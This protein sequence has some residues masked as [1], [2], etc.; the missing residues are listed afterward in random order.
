MNPEIKQLRDKLKGL[1]LDGMIVYN[2]ANVRYLT[3]FRFRRLFNNNTK[4]KCF[5]YRWKVY[6]TS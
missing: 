6:T 3:R 2:P 5:C 1:K 4:R